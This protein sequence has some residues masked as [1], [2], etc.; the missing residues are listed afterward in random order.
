MARDSTPR[1]RKRSRRSI[2]ASQGSPLADISNKKRRLDSVATKATPGHFGV[3]ANAISGAFG[4]GQRRTLSNKQATSTDA[5]KCYEVPDSDDERQRI[6]AR[7]TLSKKSKEV[8]RTGRI[9]D[10]YDLPGSDDELSEQLTSQDSPGRVSSKRS[11]SLILDSS[12]KRTPQKTSPASRLL[13][14]DSENTAEDPLAAESSPSKQL[15]SLKTQEN[16]PKR[17]RNVE[18]GAAPGQGASPSAAKTQ[19]GRKKRNPLD[20]LV[21]DGTPKLKGI[22][23]P[24][25][26]QHDEHRPRKSVVFDNKSTNKNDEVF[27][28]DPP[29][30][31]A[32]S[33]PTTQAAKPTAPIGPMG[34]SEVEMADD[35]DVPNDEDTETDEEVCALCLKPDSKRPNL[36]VF[37]DKCDMAVHQKCY[38]LASVP[39]GDWLCKECS[40]G[41]NAGG[42]GDQD[43]LRSSTAKI[44]EEVPSISHFEQHLRSLQRVLLDRCSGRRALKLCG[45]DDAYEKTYQLVEQTVVAGEGNSM[46]VIGSRGCGKTTVSLLRRLLIAYD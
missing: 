1:S 26:R 34:D 28:P 36:I 44:D 13:F 21:I 3:I 33:T 4:F 24:T 40:Q 35:L 42:R 14:V 11:Q 30:K 23:T 25:K 39:K 46:L 6:Q 15:S 20:D 10:A 38:G 2:E 22:L 16:T 45:H 18:E 7:Q 27:F 8:N 41:N 19:S 9:D 29:S 32:K 43:L 5:D 31:G 17:I 12:L 37:C